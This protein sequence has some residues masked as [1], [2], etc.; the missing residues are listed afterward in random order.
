MEMYGYTKQLLKKKGKKRHTKQVL[1]KEITLQHHKL[2]PVFLSLCYHFKE[3]CFYK[4]LVGTAD[5]DIQST[6]V[7]GSP[8]HVSHYLEFLTFIMSYHKMLQMLSMNF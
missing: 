5:F 8:L 6:P 2:N 1:P 7:K 4:K 3:E